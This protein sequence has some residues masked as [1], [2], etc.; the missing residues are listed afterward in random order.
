MKIALHEKGPVVSRIARGMMRSSEWRLTAAEMRAQ[1]DRSLDLGVTTFDHAD[2]YGDYTCEALF[3]EALAGMPAARARMQV[4]TKCGIKPVSGRHPAR[5]VKQYDTSRAHIAASVERSLERL[6]TDYIDLLLIHRPD[7]LM[8]P[9]EVAAAFSALRDAGKVLFFGVSNFSPSQFE[10]LSSR[11]PFPLVTNQIECS[12]LQTKPFEDGTLDQC[13]RLG[14]VPMAWSP[15]GGGSVFDGR[16]KQILRVRKT[17]LTLC[18]ALGIDSIEKL[19]LAW[20]LAHPARIV[21]VIGTGRM[22]RVEEA[23]EALSMELD[24]AVWFEIL[25]ASRGSDVP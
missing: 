22:D 15:L 9:D 13:M 20:L 18:R 12:V 6:H 8:D 19:A 17:L 23:V 1:I 25:R 4:V 16:T 3:G 24:R 21:P 7:P 14:V 2:I 10:L 5:A 11:V